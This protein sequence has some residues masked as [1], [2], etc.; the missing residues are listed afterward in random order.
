[1]RHAVRRTVLDVI[2]PSLG[3]ATLW[4][5]NMTVYLD[6]L[7]S[8]QNDLSALVLKQLRDSERSDAETIITVA[9]LFTVVLLMCPLVLNAVYSVTSNIQSFSFTLVT[10]YGLCSLRDVNMGSVPG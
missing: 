1:M 9:I 4:H 5:D 2:K 10:R 3:N 8:M 7:L 6:A